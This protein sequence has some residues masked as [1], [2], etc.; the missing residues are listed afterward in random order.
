MNEPPILVSG[1]LVVQRDDTGSTLWIRADRVV[2]VTEFKSRYDGDLTA[3]DTGNGE[4][5]IVRGHASAIV[6]A[7]WRMT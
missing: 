7:L 4:P 2:A 1:V 3:I 6:E 5:W